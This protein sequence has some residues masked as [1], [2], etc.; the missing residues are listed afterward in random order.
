[1]KTIQ[2][3]NCSYNDSVEDWILDDMIHSSLLPF[4]TWQEETGVEVIFMK[5]WGVATYYPKVE[6]TA[7]FKSETDASFFL[8]SFT[9]LP[10]KTLKGPS[11]SW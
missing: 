3:L 5:H 2:I 1:M 4:F 9:N 8:A 6:I 7:Q 11:F 10:Y